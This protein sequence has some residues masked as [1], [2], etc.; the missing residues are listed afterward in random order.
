MKRAAVR[1]LADYGVEKGHA[2]FNELYQALYRGTCFALVGCAALMM[3]HALIAALTAPHDADGP[4]G[5]REYA[6]RAGHA[7]ADV[8][9]TAGRKH[10]GVWCSPTQ[11]I[12][13]DVLDIWR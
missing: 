5:Y 12:I 6:Q 4:G 1:C 13:Y 7:R 3:L 2:E 11:V 8:C 9:R 10:R